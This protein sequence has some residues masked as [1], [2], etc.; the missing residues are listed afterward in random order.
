LLSTYES[1]GILE[2]EEQWRSGG[3]RIA[4]EFFVSKLWREGVDERE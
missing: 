1:I 4:R 2:E 3:R